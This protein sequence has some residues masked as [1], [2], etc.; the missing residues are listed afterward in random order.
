MDEVVEADALDGVLTALLNRRPAAV[1]V[2]FAED[3][4]IVPM[5]TSEVFQRHST[6]EVPSVRSNLLAFVVPA[7]QM[8]VVTI[9][10]RARQT[11]VA[12]GTVHMREAPERP[13]VLAFV[14]ARHRYGVRLGI[15]VDEGISAEDPIETALQ[16]AVSN[17]PRTAEV[18]KSF[19]G[20]IVAIDER[21]TRMLGWTADEMVGRRSLDFLHPDDHERAIANWLELRPEQQTSRVRV[22]HRTKDDDLRWL[23]VEHTIHFH[24]DP[25]RT[26]VAAQFTDI[27]DEMA[28]H[29]A[30]DQREKLFRRLTESLP[31]GLFLVHTDRTVGYAN[32]RL[33]TILGVSAAATLDEQFAT[34]DQVDRPA[35]DAAFRA[36]LE[37]GVDRQVEVSITLLDNGNRSSGEQRRCT[38]T[39]AALS[40][41]EGAPG[42]LVTVED[43]TESA[44]MREELQIR[45]SFDALTGCY[46][47]A[48][49]MIALQQALTADAGGLA[50]FFVD[51]DDFK[52]VNDEL[53]HA[54]GDEILMYAAGALL[55]Q[56][57]SGDLVG[58]IGGD[59]FL[60]LCHGVGTNEM[61][62]EIGARIRTVLHH[63]VP[64]AGTAVALRA[65]IGIARAEPGLSA[66]ALVAR[67]DAAMY[68]GK[69][70]RSDAPVLHGSFSSPG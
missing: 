32:A 16:F 37:E 6:I 44:R 5:P 29:E 67:A 34:V 50:V 70:R 17:R 7:D 8:T 43:V 12:R 10:E 27:S 65:S 2:A 61:A 21:V 26:R 15:L 3:G 62:L 9:W 42:A 60:L 63:A 49:T 52:S 53:G 66:Q 1:L 38:V 23:E 46:N 14:D 59:E 68:D 30:I 35:L 41:Q 19:Y 45:A 18:Q 28:A 22:R 25:D 39:L 4:T 24:E 33:A 56:V 58:R 13:I 11:G 48:S 55:E 40:D 51:L 47:R 31:L 57:R 20:N 64:I 54:A 69:R 36:T